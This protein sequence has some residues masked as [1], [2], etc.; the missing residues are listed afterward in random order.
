MIR[1]TLIYNAV[2]DAFVHALNDI[3]NKTAQHKFHKTL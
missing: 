2:A 3:F 1:L